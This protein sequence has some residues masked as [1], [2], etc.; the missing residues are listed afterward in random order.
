[1]QQTP[2]PLHLHGTRLDAPVFGTE[3]ESFSLTD[4]FGPNFEGAVIERA[5][6]LESEEIRR[7]IRKDYLYLSKMLHT[8]T[9]ARE[10]RGV[11]HPA[12]NRL[13]EGIEVKIQSVRELIS[14]RLIDLAKRFSHKPDA[15]VDVINARPTQYK[16]PIASPHAN[17]YLDLLLEADA[18]FARAKAAWLQNLTKPQ[19]HHGRMRE[20]KKSL[21][22]IKMDVTEARTACFKMLKRISAGLDSADPEAARL[23]NEIRD[24]ATGLLNDARDDAEVM[25]TLKVSDGHDLAAVAG[26]AAPQETEPATGEALAAAGELTS[27]PPPGGGEP[28]AAQTEVPQK[29][30]RKSTATDLA[31]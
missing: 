13:E 29:R 7:L 17:S 4:V 1:M 11:D 14:M 8:L 22:A 16:A 28:D 27:V 10:Y 3:S 20:I 26:E 2:K 15:V 31:A 30:T 23:Q 12:L 5:L 24:V 18:F 9:R 6:R 19:D 21:Y 25:S